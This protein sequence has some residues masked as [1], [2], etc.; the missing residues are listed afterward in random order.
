MQTGGKKENKWTIGELINAGS[1]L[2]L[3][4]IAFITFAFL[5]PSTLNDIGR[6]TQLGSQVT[7]IPGFTLS[8][9]LVYISFSITLLVSVIALF[10]LFFHRA[11]ISNSFVKNSNRKFYG[12]LMIYILVQLV[13]TE[14]FAYYNP[15]FTNQ[16]PFQETAG[17]QNFVFSF[18]VLEETVLYV[19]IPLFIALAVVGLMRGIPLLKF[20]RLYN[21][22]RTETLIIALAISLFSTVLIAGSPITYISDFASFTVLNFIF[23]RFGFF[24]AFLTNFAVALTNV[25]ATLVAGNNAVSTILPLFLFFLGFLGVYSLV[26]VTLVNQKILPEG[27]LRKSAPVAAPRMRPQIEPFVYSRCP[28]CGSAVYHVIS[29]DMSLKC[30]KCEHELPRDAVGER[31][32][33]IEFGK[34]NRY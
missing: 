16:F 7:G 5:F 32:I 25:T 8:T 24:R 33:T 2:L 31:N 20:I 12:F 11:D 23:L 19:M 26:Q 34:A 4:G 17:V 22:D 1:G 3:V 15:G 27:D 29:R 21:G 10:S 14:I 28:E 18:L 6:I 13:L 30:E 9:S